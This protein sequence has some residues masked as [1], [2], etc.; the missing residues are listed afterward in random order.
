MLYFY[1]GTDSEKM[2]DALAATLAQTKLPV[3]RVT[4]AHAEADLEAALMGGGMFGERRVVVLDGTL[5]N[6]AFRPRVLAALESLKTSGDTYFIV[7]ASLEA[8]TRKRVEKCAEKSERFD[9]PK[10]AKG[11]KTIFALANALQ[12]GKKK[13]LWVGYQKELAAGEAPEAIHGVL[14]WAAKQQLLRRPADARAKRL[15]AELAE[16]PHMARRSGEDLEY[17]LERF[18]LAST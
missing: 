18:V 15:V 11:G 4:D 16:L 9:A 10:A 14:F 7:E 5:A 17:A 1:F 2:R 13:E 12:G 6:D 3:V 8:E